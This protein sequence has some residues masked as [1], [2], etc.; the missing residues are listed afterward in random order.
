MFCRTGEHE[1]TN[2][3]LFQTVQAERNFKKKSDNDP[4]LSHFQIEKKLKSRKRINC[5]HLTIFCN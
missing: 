4:L 5:V 1:S 3:L 2:R